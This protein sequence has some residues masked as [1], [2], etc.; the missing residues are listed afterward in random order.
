MKKYVLI[1]L[2]NNYITINSTTAIDDYNIPCIDTGKYRQVVKRKKDSKTIYYG[3][4]KEYLKKHPLSIS[5]TYE[6]I[7]PINI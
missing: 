2:W 4:K 1:Q 3:T 7:E 5:Q 6:I